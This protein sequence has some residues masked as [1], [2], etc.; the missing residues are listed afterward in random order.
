[1]MNEL[2]RKE[3]IKRIKG[4]LEF[5][6]I[7]LGVHD[8]DEIKIIKEAMSSLVCLEQYRWERD[9]A[10]E[11]LEELG[12]SFGAEIDDDIKEAISKLRGKRNE[13]S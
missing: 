5:G 10:I 11:Q 12:I 13:M 3:A 7:D 1:M 2:D 9:I 4:Q 6:Y 8:Q